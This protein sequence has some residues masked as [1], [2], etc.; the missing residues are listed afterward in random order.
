MYLKLKVHPDSRKDEVIRKAPDQFEI[1]VREP[2]EDNRANRSALG[3][4]QKYLKIPDGSLRLV[5]GAHSRN[6]IAQISD[7]C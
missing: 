2:A 7:E 1:W 3:L 4:L 6:K 5:R